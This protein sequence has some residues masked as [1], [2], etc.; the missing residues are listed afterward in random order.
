LACGSPFA[1][2]EPASAESDPVAQ[3]RIRMQ[4]MIAAGLC[5]DADADEAIAMMSDMAD[6]QLAGELSDEDALARIFELGQAQLIKRE[7][8]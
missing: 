7:G 6:Q 1:V 5:T 3:A 2:T 4:A 8:N